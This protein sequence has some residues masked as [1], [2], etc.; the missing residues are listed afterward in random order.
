MNS[1]DDLV[2]VIIPVFNSETFLEESIKSIINQT[3]KN[4]EI[5]AIDDG[6]T[7]NSL[8]ILQ[9]YADKIT[10]HSQEN[11]GLAS[12]LSVGIKMMKGKWFKWLSPDDT[13]FPNAIE[14]LLNEAKKLPENTIVYSNWELIDKNNKVLRSFSE[15]NYNN[16][17]NFEFNVRLLDGQQI[18]VNTSLI[19]T[20]LFKKGCLIRETKDPVAI[21][22]DFFLRAALKYNTNFHLIPNVLVKYRIHKKQLSHENFSKSLACVEDIKKDVLS[23]LETKQQEKYLNSLK[24]YKKKKPISR[25]TMDAGL[26]LLVENFPEWVS[27]QILTLYLN[28][29]RRTR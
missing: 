23:T 24:E 20:N 8:K 13:L 9:L 28:K 10:I 6:S 21:D 2:S 27:D 11:Q 16:L 19:P 17:S 29:I 12:A 1:N 3:H 22:Y 25:K 15:Y 7:D 5:I 26:K 14:V 4:Q 18:N